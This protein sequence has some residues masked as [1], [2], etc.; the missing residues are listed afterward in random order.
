MFKNLLAGLFGGGGN[1]DSGSASGRVFV[2]DQSYELQ[3]AYSYA[4]TKDNELWVYLTD[5]PLTDKQ[6]TK[7]WPIH[8]AAR[9][10]QVHGVKLCLDPE[11]SEPKSLS[12][13]LLMPPESKNH[14]LTS[15][16]SSGTDPRFEQ[17]SLPPVKLAGQ[18]SYEGG[19]IFDS[20]PYGFEAEFEFKDSPPA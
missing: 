9:A 11:D 6:V 14:S 1:V 19:G 13:L 5:S 3:H 20:P 12:A 18:I 2:G 8:E 15:I 10:E 7:R 4:A 17:L 16:S